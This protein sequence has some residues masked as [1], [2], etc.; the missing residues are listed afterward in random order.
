MKSEVLT[1]I[2]ERNMKKIILIG[3]AACYKSSVGKLLADKF[4]CEFVDTDAE[5]ERIEN[6][7]VQQ[8]FE[9]HGEQYFRERESELLSTLKNGNMVV[10]CGGGCVLSPV[11]AEFAR[12]S[13]VVCLTASAET[14]HARL[15]AIPRPLF[16]GLT[17]QELSRYIQTRAPLYSKYSDITLST[18]GKTSNQV[19]EEIYNI[20]KL[21]N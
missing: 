16:D 10:A 15:G 20:K 21:R 9:A 1:R 17:V 13:I 7:S 4:K 12:D 18:D 5:I 8:I 19:A 2:H 6:M 14:I 11:F 3:F